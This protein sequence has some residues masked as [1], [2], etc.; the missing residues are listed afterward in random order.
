M[1][2]IERSGYYAFLKRKPGKR[3]LANQLLDKKIIPLFEKHYHRYGAPRLTDELK[4]Q[5][6][7][8]SKN[9]VARRLKQLK[10]RAK[11]KKKFK[12]T[13]DSRHNLSL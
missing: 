13:T 9:R 3:H 10:L 1:L 7:T 4:D 12:A 5:G 11:A 8:C 2:C 6:E